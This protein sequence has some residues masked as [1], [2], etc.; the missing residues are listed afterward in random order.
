ML[1]NMAS[2]LFIHKRIRT[3]E[4]KAKALRRYVEPLL[5]KSKNDTTHSRRIVFSYL[6]H[7]DAVKTLFT[8]IAPQIMDRPGGYTR[9]LKLGRRQG[10]GAEMVLME[11]VDFN[12]YLEGKPL[13]KT[14][15]KRRPKKKQE[16]KAPQQKQAEVKP[17]DTA[18]VEP[19]ADAIAEPALETAHFI[20]TSSEVST[21]TT[22]SNTEA[23][24]SSDANA[25]DA[26]QN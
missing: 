4:A 23:P 15:S 16:S 26:A 14:A 1:S 11:L 13:A 7:K 21:E 5:T 2:S 20:E 25:D 3:T 8:E 17:V 22:E 18:P 19:V 6:Q 10:D 9:I 24:A 12:E